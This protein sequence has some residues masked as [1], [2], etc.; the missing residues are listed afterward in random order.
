[1]F[2][3]DGGYSHVDK[4]WSLHTK[5]STLPRL[6]ALHYYYFSKRNPFKI[7]NI[8]LPSCPMTP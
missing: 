8:V 1:M 7:T 6:D 3:D 5:K 4:S 2:D